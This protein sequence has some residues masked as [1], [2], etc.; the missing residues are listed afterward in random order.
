MKKVLLA[1]AVSLAAV[2]S[3]NAAYNSGNDPLLIDGNGELMLSIFD[4]TTQNSYAQDLGITFDQMRAGYNGT[5]TLDPAHI[6]VFGGDYSNVQFS[7]MAGSNTQYTNDQYNEFDYSERGVIYSMVPGQAVWDTNAGNNDNAIG[8]VLAQY[9][10]YAQGNGLY[11]SEIENDGYSVT[12]GGQGYADNDV[13]GVGYFES[14][15]NRDMSAENGGTLELWL[16]GY[17][18]DDGFGEPLNLLLSNVT[19]SLSGGLGSIT[20]AS[21]VGAEVPVPAA[22]WLLG[23]ALLGLGGVARRRRA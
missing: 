11:I 13:T 22:A 3:A 21:A 20:F 23:S 18:Q 4:R 2:S 17:T 12:A 7:L 8:G 16:K 19:M 5:I 9:E 6:A 14:V 15:F 1:V 10:F